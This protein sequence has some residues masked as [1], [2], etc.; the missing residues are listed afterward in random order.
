MTMGFNGSKTY[1]VGVATIMWAA[2][3]FVAGKVDG[4]TAI[5]GILFA[6]TMMGIRH[7]MPPKTI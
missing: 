6:L 4:N 7:G 3:G 2:G 5:Q 1:I